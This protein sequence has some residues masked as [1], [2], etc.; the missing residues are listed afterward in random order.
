MTVKHKDRKSTPTAR[1]AI[2]ETPAHYLTDQQLLE[3]LLNLPPDRAAALLSRQSLYAMRGN[4]ASELAARHDLNRQQALT[5]Y[6]AI[7]L[8]NR[9]R[10]NRSRRKSIC[11]PDA[12]AG[13]FRPRMEGLPQEEIHVMSLNTRNHVMEIRQI[14]RGNVN[15][16]HVRPAEVLRPAVLLNAPAIIMAHNHP[17]GDPTPSPEDASVTRSIRNAGRMIEIQLLDHIIIG[18]NGRFISMNKEKRGFE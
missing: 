18:S 9:F 17:S 4:T 3:G 8:A 16:S 1:L 12:A 13:L 7:S 14:Y 6:C 5:L 2:W 15:S 11:S 10:K